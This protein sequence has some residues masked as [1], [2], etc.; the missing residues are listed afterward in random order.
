[1]YY[2]QLPIWQKSQTLLLEIEKIVRGFSRYHKYSMGLE[3]RQSGLRLCKAIHRALT[4]KKSKMKLIQLMT[5]LIDDIKFQLQ[6]A[7]KLQAFNGFAQFQLLT[8][9]VV[10]LGKQAGGW[11]KKARAEAGYNRP[12]S[13]RL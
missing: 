3:L 4:R 10:S 2:K 8:E 13:G 9:L 7:K 6:L 5:E 12:Q 1:M 11:Y